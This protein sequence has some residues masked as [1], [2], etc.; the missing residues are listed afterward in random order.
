M[1][2]PLTVPLTV[3]C[4]MLAACEQKS[5]QNTSS[6]PAPSANPTEAVAEFDGSSVSPVTAEASPA[7]KANTSATPS[8]EIASSNVRPVFKSETA[9]EAAN[10]YLDSYQAFVNG[11]NNAPKPPRGDPM[12]S[13]DHVRNTLQELGRQS[14]ELEN[15]QKRM[16]T[17]LTPGEKK[18]VEQYKRR[19]ERGGQ[20]ADQNQ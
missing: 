16:E 10:Q 11:V 13:L 1:K 12:A 9:T 18:I 14:T 3:L 2:L 17:E 7:S 6:T 4:L 5:A 19:L 8:A 15:R 20:M